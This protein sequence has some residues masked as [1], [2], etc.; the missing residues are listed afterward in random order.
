MTIPSP[1]PSPAPAIA[2]GGPGAPPVHDAAADTVQGHRDDPLPR[3]LP[4][5]RDRRGVLGPP[6]IRGCESESLV[7]RAREISV[8]ARKIES[9]HVRR[10]GIRRLP[11]LR[12]HEIVAPRGNRH[13][14]EN[15]EYGNDDHQLDH[16]DSPLSHGTFLAWATIHEPSPFLP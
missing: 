12:P 7:A 5:R 16:G 6:R 15:S 9:R 10:G 8:P 11:D 4:R 2:P 14:G 3:A 13:R 1:A